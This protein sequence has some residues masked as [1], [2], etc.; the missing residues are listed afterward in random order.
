M[1]DGACCGRAGL[2]RA[3]ILCWL[4]MCWHHWGVCSPSSGVDC[5]ARGFGSTRNLHVACGCPAGAAAAAVLDVGPR[6][7]GQQLAW[8]GQ[9][10][11]GPGEHVQ[12]GGDLLY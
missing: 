12:G 8:V 5:E 6:P 10:Q 1:L 3:I 4:H 11:P 7:G 9:H 2:R